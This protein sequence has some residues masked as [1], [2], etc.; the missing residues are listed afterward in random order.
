VEYCLIPQKILDL[1]HSFHHLTH[2]YHLHLKQPHHL[3]HLQ[4]LLMKKL[5]Y[6]LRF[7]D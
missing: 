7:L 4:M 3:H 2:H 1:H 6:F 5:N